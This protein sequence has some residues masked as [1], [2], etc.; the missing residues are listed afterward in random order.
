MRCLGNGCSEIFEKRAGGISAPFPRPHLAFDL[1]A[2]VAPKTFLFS[3]F[4]PMIPLSGRP[5]YSRRV[6]ILWAHRQRGHTFK[7]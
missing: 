5:R 7:L 3:C 4:I 1:F 6:F 2:H